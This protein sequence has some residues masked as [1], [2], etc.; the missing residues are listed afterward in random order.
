MYQGSAGFKWYHVSGLKIA[1]PRSEGIDIPLL[2]LYVPI[3]ACPKYAPYMDI[4]R[5]TP[6]LEPFQDLN[7]DTRG[8]IC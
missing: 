2:K 7:G 6:L 1:N 3:A 8:I 4:T 5:P